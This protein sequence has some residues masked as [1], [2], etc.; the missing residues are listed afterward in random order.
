MQHVFLNI[1]ENSTMF[2]SEAIALNTIRVTRSAR[3]REQNHVEKILWVITKMHRCITRKKSRAP[4][5][6]FLSLPKY[7]A[8]S[9]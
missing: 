3:A 4:W 8:N 2:F 6:R 5:Q 1:V 9:S 7:R